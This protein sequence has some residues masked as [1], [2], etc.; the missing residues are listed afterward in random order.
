MSTLSLEGKSI[1]RGVKGTAVI[2]GASSGL[3]SVFANRLALRGYDLILVARR[4]NRLVALE[5]HLNSEYGVTAKAIVADLT[6]KTDLDS[7]VKTISEDSSITMLVNNAGAASM[8]PIAST[9]DV[10]LYTMIDLNITAL[11][12]LTLAVLPGF[13]ER[14]LGTVINIGSSLSV[15][16]PPKTGVYSGT[17]AYVL[18]FTSGLQQELAGTKVIAQIVLPAKT[19]TEIWKNTGVPLSSLN[20]A[21]IM[22]AENC[23]DAALAGLDQSESATLPSVENYELWLNFEEARRTLY[24]ASQ[25]GKP[26]SRY[27]IGF[28]RKR[29]NSK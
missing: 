14:D 8:K 11:T 28:D 20:Q 21:A 5:K 18:N 10:E 29:A 23:V 12:R 4:A 1:S 3:G 15:Y 16:T 27:Q 25:T 22:S 26:A 7:L 24:S 6:A 17:K 19:A 13:K 9:S 2:T